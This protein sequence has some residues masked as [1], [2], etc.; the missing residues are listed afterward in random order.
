MLLLRF[1]ILLAV[2]KYFSPSQFALL[3]ASFEVYLCTSILRSDLSTIGTLVPMFVMY[4]QVQPVCKQ[5]S[6]L[7]H[8]LCPGA[9][10]QVL[11]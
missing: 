2:C 10:L 5:P 9:S 6:T 8:N 3:V 11:R 4:L 7:L 1:Y